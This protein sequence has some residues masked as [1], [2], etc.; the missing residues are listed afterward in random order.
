MTKNPIISLSQAQ[1]LQGK[2]NF[3]QSEKLAILAQ[4]HAELTFPD[5]V[6]VGQFIQ[7]VMTGQYDIDTGWFYVNPSHPVNLATGQKVEQF[8]SRETT[9]SAETNEKLTIISFA[10]FQE[11]TKFSVHDLEKLPAT[12]QAYN[13]PDFLIPEAEA[14]RLYGNYDAWLDIHAPKKAKVVAEEPVSHVVAEEP[15]APAVEKPVKE[16]VKKSFDVKVK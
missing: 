16:K 9:I 1:F 4:A 15:Q 8:L 5:D 3:L 14:Q 11:A 12:Y 10:P 6:A 7:A 13:Q 2:K